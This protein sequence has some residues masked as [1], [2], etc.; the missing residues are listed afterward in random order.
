M[1]Y[2]DEDVDVT[3]CDCCSPNDYAALLVPWA[4]GV[5]VFGVGVLLLITIAA[6]AAR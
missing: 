3:A 4:V 5:I 6:H 2:E 1:T